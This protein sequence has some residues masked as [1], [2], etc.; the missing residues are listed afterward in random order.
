[1]GELPSYRQSLTA[2]DEEKKE[3]KK[4]GGK[5]EPCDPRTTNNRRMASMITF[6]L[7]ERGVTIGEDLVFFYK[8]EMKSTATLDVV[9]FTFFLCLCA[10]ES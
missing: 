5:V 10:C 9:F 3:K 1:M 2:R 6:L 4:K 7:R 8:V